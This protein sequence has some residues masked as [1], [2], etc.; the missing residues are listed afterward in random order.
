MLNGC[1]HRLRVVGGQEL[2]NCLHHAIVDALSNLAGAR[3]DCRPC[4]GTFP[5][6]SE[7]ETAAATDAEFH[8]LSRRCAVAHCAAK[9]VGQGQ[10]GAERADG[11]EEGTWNI[12]AWLLAC[13][14]PQNI[15]GTYKAEINLPGTW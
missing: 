9:H 2:G 13:V 7:G 3:C 5:V 11:D 4:Q 12:E 6:A 10:A 15:G 8:E 1:L 14:P